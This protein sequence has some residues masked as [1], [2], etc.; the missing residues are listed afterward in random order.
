[1]LKGQQNNAS[2]KTTD[3]T[4][5]IQ[6]IYNSLT[7]SHFCSKLGVVF[8]V[9]QQAHGTSISSM[10]P[11]LLY[12]IALL[13]DVAAAAAALRLLRFWT[14]LCRTVKNRSVSHT[15]ALSP[16]FVITPVHWTVGTFMT[17]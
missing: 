3:S 16:V 7:R 1:V 15:H 4:V 12:L 6:G 11:H 13:M 14:S 10:R 8:K 2:S 17:L 5:N 9:L